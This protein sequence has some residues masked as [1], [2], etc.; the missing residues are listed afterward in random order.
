MSTTKQQS[1]SNAIR[2]SHSALS[3][4]TPNQA[5]RNRETPR[6]NETKYIDSKRFNGCDTSAR[7]VFG[8][9]EGTLRFEYQNDCEHPKNFIDP[10]I[11]NF[12]SSIFLATL[13]D[14]V[15][16]QIESMQ[17]M[18]SLVCR[19]W[20]IGVQ[21]A[22]R[23][24]SEPAKI[25]CCASLGLSNRSFSTSTSKNFDLAED[26]AAS[27]LSAKKLAQEKFSHAKRFEKNLFVEFSARSD[28]LDCSIGRAVKLVHP[29]DVSPLLLKGR[30]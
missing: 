23:F 20:A 12:S 6:L 30:V 27:R 29:L 16:S 5:F 19:L 13:I 18:K 2:A 9:R 17:P 26:L 25:L 15:S 14:S 4:A 28:W 8:F 1:E 22:N 7:S 10:R 24:R 3:L 11:T 21:A